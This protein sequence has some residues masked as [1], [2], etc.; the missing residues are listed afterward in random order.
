MKTIPDYKWQ[1]LRTIKRNIKFS[2][3]SLFPYGIISAELTSSIIYNSQ[4]T[5]GLIGVIPFVLTNMYFLSKLY[6]FPC[7]NC[8]QE[9]VFST[10]QQ[11]LGFQPHT[12]ECS[13][14]G[15][16]EGSIYPILFDKHKQSSGK[17]DSPTNKTI[18]ILYRAIEHTII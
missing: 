16:E 3:W 17:I 1:E 8:G 7:P 6:A 15:I 9:Y 10:L 14:C 12:E 18:K 4:L 2:N 11:E 13:K 5:Q